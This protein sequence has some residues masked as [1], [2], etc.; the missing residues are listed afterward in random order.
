MR[1]F[2][3]HYTDRTVTVEEVQNKVKEEIEGAGKLLGYRAM[4]KKIRM[5]H[6]LCVPRELVHCAMYL[7]NPKLLETELRAL[8]EKKKNN[9][10]FHYI[11]MF[12][13]YYDHRQVN[14][15]YLNVYT[16]IDVQKIKIDTLGN[17]IIR[18]YKSRLQYIIIV[19]K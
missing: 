11:D 17:T 13:S 19:Q 15:W 14:K 18:I 3:I 10:F 7:E 5:V 9:N 16:F 2:G 1:Y 6:K 12:R 8:K 4:H